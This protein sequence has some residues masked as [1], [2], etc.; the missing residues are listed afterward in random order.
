[1]DCQTQPGMRQVHSVDVPDFRPL[2]RLRAHVERH[3]EGMTGQHRKD[4][5]HD[6]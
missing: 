5:Q 6:P 3:P 1:M 4:S 2:D